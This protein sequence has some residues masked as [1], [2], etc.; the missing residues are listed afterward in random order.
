MLSKKGDR[1]G[2]LVE[3]RTEIE[4]KG[5]PEH[6]SDYLR[7]KME[8]N[9]MVMDPGVSREDSIQIINNDLPRTFCQTEFF[10]ETEE[11]YANKAI[12][13]WILQSFTVLW[14]D[15]GYV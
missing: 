9:L 5:K 11:G 1:V 2:Q 7:V 8:Y 14:P 15:I 13:K 3:K 12:L 6:D 10:A 4:R